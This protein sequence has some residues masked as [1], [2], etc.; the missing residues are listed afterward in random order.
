MRR[1]IGSG[2]RVR[3]SGFGEEESSEPKPQTPNPKPSPTVLIHV[4]WLWALG[5][6]FFAWA[7]VVKTFERFV[8]WGTYHIIRRR[9]RE[10]T[11]RGAPIDVRR[12]YRVEEFF[13]RRTHVAF[14]EATLRGFAF[15]GRSREAA[16]LPAY[17]EEHL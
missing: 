11:R 5:R 15:Q 3:G 17:I 2:F 10:Q 13:I 16:G 7:D 14:Y 12:L 9:I 4:Y 6:L 1:K 8:R